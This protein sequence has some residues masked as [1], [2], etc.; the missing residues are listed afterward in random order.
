MES[1]C[2]TQFRLEETNCT[3]RRRTTEFVLT[4]T[5]MSMAGSTTT[6]PSVP[7]RAKP[8]DA[9]LH[10]TVSDFK[11]SLFFH[12]ERPYFVKRPLVDSCR[13]FS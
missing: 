3:S 7:Q 6:V 1:F 13:S 4:A 10:I 5:M 9:A 12:V 11:K 2:G 8:E